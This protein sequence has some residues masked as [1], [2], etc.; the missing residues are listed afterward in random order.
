MNPSTVW[1][2]LAELENQIPQDPTAALVH[3]RAMYARMGELATTTAE[4]SFPGFEALMLRLI[5][6]EEELTGKAAH[7]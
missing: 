7:A 6:R 4:A 3:I 1:L 5:A 2:G